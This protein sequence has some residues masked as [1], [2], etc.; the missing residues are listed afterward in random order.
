[1]TLVGTVDD[2]LSAGQNGAGGLVIA[3]HEPRTTGDVGGQ[4]GRRPSFNARW[5]L[6]RHIKRTSLQAAYDSRDLLG[7][8]EARDFG[9]AFRQDM[10]VF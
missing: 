5:W 4:Y 3:V 6:L 9:Q 1:M 8:D 2:P 7:R 10:S